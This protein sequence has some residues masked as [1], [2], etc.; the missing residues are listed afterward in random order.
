MPAVTL[1]TVT[2][3]ADG[4]REP[5]RWMSSAFGVPL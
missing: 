3:A 2:V 1:Y 5:C 4:T